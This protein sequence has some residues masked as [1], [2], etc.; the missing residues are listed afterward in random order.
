MSN[1]YVGWIGPRD[2]PIIDGPG[3]TGT[4]SFNVTGSTGATVNTVYSGAIGTSQY[5]VGQIVHALK[6]LGFLQM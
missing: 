5:S 1:Q 3:A 4:L 2:Q 6:I